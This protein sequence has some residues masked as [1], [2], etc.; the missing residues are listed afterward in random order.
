MTMVM[1]AAGLDDLPALDAM[2]RSTGGGFVNLPPDRDKLRDRLTAAIA[3][4]GREQGQPDDDR[5]LFV[6]EDGADACGT[7]QIFA[8]VGG[9]TPFYSYR[10]DRHSAW[11]AGLDRA[12]ESDQ[13]TI[14]TDH[15]GCS[16]VGG[17]FLRA[18]ARAAGAGA[19]LARSRYLFI[20]MHRTRFADTTIAEL[21]GVVD[22]D[23]GAPFWDGI[24]ARF[25]GIGFAQADAFN[26]ANGTHAL[27]EMMPRTPVLLAMLDPRARDVVG[28]PH[29]SGRPAMRLLE[30]EGFRQ[31]RYIDLFDGGP[32]VTAATDDIATIRAARTATVRAT[33]V[34]GGAP[35]IVASGRLAAFRCCFGTVAP[36][37]D[38]IAID[39]VAAA[40]LGVAIGD[41]LTYAPR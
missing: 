31:D 8:R 41:T 26:A 15:H 12:I 18:D 27:A 33:T 32:T 2:A 22:D 25:F 36:H 4:F 24:A 11:C 1:R 35:V 14:C 6:L 34:T 23:G 13:L 7:C 21:R 16:E 38:G 9:S 40:A 17:L 19:L 30:K 29:P 20:A 39:P 10:I 37:G 3:A 5:F 28:V